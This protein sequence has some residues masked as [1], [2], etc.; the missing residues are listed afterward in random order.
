MQ[1]RIGAYR[2][3]AHYCS[4]QRPQCPPTQLAQPTYVRVTFNP[5]VHTHPDRC[6]LECIKGRVKERI[7]T[8]GH[9]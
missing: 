4:K 3:S 9:M 5:G 1:A 2:A 6:M 7:G 8:D